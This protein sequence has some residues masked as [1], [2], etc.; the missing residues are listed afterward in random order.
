MEQ[1]ETSEP[2]KV[3]VLAEGTDVDAPRERERNEITV[4]LTIDPPGLDALQ[5]LV[6][7][8]ERCGYEME[9]A[10]E[11]IAKATGYGVMLIE[12]RIDVTTHYYGPFGEEREI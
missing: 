1:V 2:E 6:F 12:T 5:T 11:Y 9:L 8:V 4:E 7:K 10:A 3:A